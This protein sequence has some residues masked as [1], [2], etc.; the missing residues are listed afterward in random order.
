MVN[1]K[2]LV[3]DDEQTRHDGFNKIFAQDQVTHA[4][5]YDGFAE[6][7]KSGPHDLVC[8]DHDLGSTADP[9]GNVVLNKTGLDAAR[10]LVALPPQLRPKQVLVH[11]HNVIASMKMVDLLREAG[12]SVTRKPYSI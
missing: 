10:A 3:L 5:D 8:L 6:A 9:D 2:V 7:L 1:K 4:M 12:I 11:S